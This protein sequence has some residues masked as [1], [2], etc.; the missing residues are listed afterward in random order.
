MRCGKPLF[1]LGRIV[2]TPGAIDALTRANQWP[3]YFLNRHA[4]GDWG[5]IGNEDK[6]E[7]EYSLQ[8]GFRILSS[9][10]TPV[11]ERLW[12]ITEADRSSTIMIRPEEY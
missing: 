11:G 5:E 10:I 9:Y 7:N 1:P 12:V 2:A 6:A 3:D 8:H 4:W